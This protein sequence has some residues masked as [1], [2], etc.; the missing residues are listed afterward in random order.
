MDKWLKLHLVKRFVNLAVRVLNRAVPRVEPTYPQTKALSEIY[1]NMYKAF[2]VSVYCGIFDDVPYQRIK[3]LRD[4]NFQHALE[5]SE[6][7]VMYLGEMDR[8]YRGWLGLAILLAADQVTTATSSLEYAAALQ[9]IRSQWEY[10][11]DESFVPKE[12]FDAHKRA[13]LEM[14]YAP[15]LWDVAHFPF[16]KQFFPRK[17]SDKVT[18]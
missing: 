16:G 12:H 4:R 8:Y 15:C 9:S 14:E 6:K 10:P 5:L 7:L 1:R 18:K 3:T 11:L 13:F 17:Q 2:S